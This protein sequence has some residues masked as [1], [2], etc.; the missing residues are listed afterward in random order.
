MV[1]ICFWAEIFYLWNFVCGAC[2]ALIPTKIQRLY[3]LLKIFKTCKIR[4]RGSSTQTMISVQNSTKVVNVFIALNWRKAYLSPE[5]IPQ[6]VRDAHKL[7][8]PHWKWIEIILKD[9]W[10][11]LY[12]IFQFWWNNLHFKLLMFLIVISIIFIKVTLIRFNQI[13]SE[14]SI[15]ETLCCISFQ[16]LCQL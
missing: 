11:I 1:K 9:K 15:R 3:S 16:Y 4:L 10:S 6:N 2:V 7:L 12:R 5:F 14:F 13:E 8:K